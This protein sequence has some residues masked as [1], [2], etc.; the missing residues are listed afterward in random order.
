MKRRARSLLKLS[1]SGCFN[2]QALVGAK[3]SCRDLLEQKKPSGVCEWVS[4]L[5]GPTRARM[6]RSKEASA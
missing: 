2:S 4:R 1:G 3:A 5:F 6:I